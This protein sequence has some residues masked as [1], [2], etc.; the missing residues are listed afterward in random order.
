MNYD[1]ADQMKRTEGRIEYDTDVSMSMPPGML[2]SKFEETDIGLDESAY[3]DYARS[4]ACDWTADTN[5]M[6]HEEPR[7]SIGNGGYLQ[8][9]YNGHRGDADEVYRPEHFDQ[10]IGDEDRDPRGSQVDPDMKQM[11][12]QSMARNRFIRFTPDGCENITGGG[13]SEAQTMADQQTLIRTVRSRMKVFDRQID[14]RRTGLRREFTHKSAANQSILVQSYGD[15]I[16]DKGLN[17]TRRANFIADLVVNSR[18]FRDEN[19]DQLLEIAKYTQVRRGQRETGP[20]D[21][22]I[23]LTDGNFGTST[24]TK[25]FKACGL[26][27]ADIIRARSMVQSSADS[28]NIDF[29]VSR[30]VMGRKTAPMC[31]DLGIILNAVAQDAEFAY[32]ESTLVG[33]TA[34]RLNRPHLS[35]VTTQQH[36]TPA[37]HILNAEIIY[38]SVKPGADTRKLCD[39]IITDVAINGFDTA[40]AAKTAK[41]I[42]STGAKLARIHDGE[43]SVEYKKVVNYKSVAMTGNVS[44]VNL[45]S[46]DGKASESDNTQNRRHDHTNYHT[47]SPN[48]SAQNMGYSDNCHA[49]RHGRGIGKKYLNRYIDRENNDSDHVSDA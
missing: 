46:N 12:R 35:T 2:M 13:R 33:K 24:N 48:H 29:A 31:K 4:V 42:M 18:K 36:L 14:G 49:E 21:N 3:T 45:V 28:G 6:E 44:E 41:M 43:E 37:H 23:I 47:A 17:I 27:M 34:A 16:T 40:K 22:S 10:F 20:Q 7:N 39:Q 11:T 25:N 32:S 30:D 19:N 1:L 5:R 9:R 15:A 26:L 8:L 38:K